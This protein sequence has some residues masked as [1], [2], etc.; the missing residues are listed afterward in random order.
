MKTIA[1]QSPI[2]RKSALA[3]MARALSLA[4]TVVIAGTSQ[5]APIGEGPPDLVAQRIL[6]GSPTV[7]AGEA[8]TQ[9]PNGR[10]LITGGQAS[11]FQIAYL[12]AVSGHR[13]EVQTYLVEGRFDHSATVLPDGSVL[14]FGGR[15][16]DGSVL[17][18]AE[19]FDPSGGVI[20]TLGAVGLLPRAGHTA[21]VLSDGEVLVAGG[22]DGAGQP[23]LQAELY[24]PV[25]RRAERIDLNLDEGRVSQLAALLPNQNVLLWNRK[26]SQLGASA[27]ELL[28]PASGTISHVGLAR[29]RGLTAELA[30]DAVPQIVRTHPERDSSGVPVSEKIVVEFN[31]RMD[32]SSFNDESV[33][34]LG[35]RGV[36]PV[37]PVSV[38][39]GVLLFVAP[40][41][42][43]LPDSSYT[44]FIEGATDE[45]GLA[46]PFTAIGFKTQALGS[47]DVDQSSSAGDQSAVGSNG[48]GTSGG[49]PANGAPGLGPVMIPP[50][51][52]RDIRSTIE[53]TLGS[54][55]LSSAEG[56]SGLSPIDDSE[57]WLPGVQDRRGTWISRR[58]HSG[59]GNRPRNE[60]VDRALY[61]DPDVLGA[62]A[63]MTPANA[64]SRLEALRKKVSDKVR[65]GRTALAGQVLRLNG[66]PLRS[67]TLSIGGRTVATDDN[68]EFTLENVPAGHQ[69]LV[70]DGR[71]AGGS[72]VQYGRFEYGADITVGEVNVLPFL[73]WMSRVDSR[74][75][76]D[77]TSPTT[78]T[79]VLTN[80][81]IPG[82]ELRLPPGTVVRDADGKIATHLS[83][84]AI[85]T[86]QPPFPLPNFPVP[87]YFTV[88]PGGAH[89]ESVDGQPT[90]GAQLV[91]PNFTNSAP[92]TRMTF[93][94]YDSQKK[95]WYVYG[96]GSVTADGT[97][98]MPDP[99]VVIYEFSGAMVSLPGNGPGVGPTPGAGGC[100]VGD[101]VDC[102]TGLFINEGTDLYIKDTIPI[103][104]RRSY[105]QLDN[106]SRGFGI[107]TNLSYDMFLVGD[108]NPYTYQ[109]LILPDGGK[110]HFS[111][112]SS[113]TTFADAVYQSTSAPGRFYGAMIT[114]TQGILD[115]WTLT[116]R[117]GTR[118]GFAEEF[119]STSA[120][121]A[122]IRVITDRNGNQLRMERD[123][124]FALTK[125]V[126]PN[127]R[128]ITLAYDTL[129]RVTDATDDLG[130][131]VHYSYTAAGEL[132]TI[133]YPLG[134][135]EHFTYDGH[136]NMLTVQDK[137]G[138]TMVTN[139]YD[140]NDRVSLQ[141]YADGNT[142]QFAYTLD[143][144]GTKVV[145]TD[146]TTLRGVVR[147]VIFNSN[148]YP[149]SITRAL[150]LP[151]QQVATITRDPATNLLS[152]V[153]DMPLNRDTAYAYDGLGNLKSITRDD[154]SAILF[155]YDPV[156]NQVTKV[157][158]ANNHA[159]NIGLDAEGNASE[160][161]DALSH[162]T[163]ISYDEQG[164]PVGL[165]DPLNHTTNLAYFGGDLSK[166]TD[167]I[168]RSTTW[169]T[170]GAGRATAVSD[171]LRNTRSIQYDALNRVTS[172]TD[173]NGNTISFTYDGNGNILTE[174]DANNNVTTF[175]YDSMN[176]IASRTDALNH[177]ET[178]T[179][180]PAGAFMTHTDR[181]SQTTRVDF[182]AFGRAA[183]VTYPDGTVTNTWDGGSRLT[184]SVD[185]VNGTITRTYDV[186]DRLTK[187]ITPEGTV[188]YTY[189]PQG[190]R[191]TFQITGQPVISYTYD[192]ADRLT[193]IQ[194]AAGT[195]NGN[196][197]QTVSIAYDNANRRSGITL[198]N[199]VTGTYTFD[200][201]NE[202]TSLVY[203]K[204][205]GTVIGDLTYT[206][207]VAGRR[208][209]SGGTLAPTVLPVATTSA[210][211][212]NVNNQQTAWNGTTQTFD[213]NGN[214]TS[215][216]TRAY[217]W[218]VRNQ[219]SSSTGSNTVTF[220]YDAFGRRRARTSSG[221]TSAYLLDGDNIAQK[222]VG[223]TKYTYITGGLDE[224]FGQYASSGMVVPLID[225][226][227]STVA[228][229]DGSQ[230]S[231]S[232]TTYRPYGVST[233]SGGA[234]QLNQQFTGHED[235]PT[236]LVYARARYYSP[237]SGRFI[238]EDP[239]GWAS[240]Q[241]N[242][243][244]YVHGMPT[245]FRDPYGL[246]ADQLYPGEIPIYLERPPIPGSSTGSQ[247]ISVGP[248]SDIPLPPVGP[249]PGESWPRE[250]GAPTPAAP[251]PPTEYH[252]TLLQRLKQL[253][254]GM[255]PP[256][257]QPERQP[258]SPTGVR[259]DNGNNSDPGG[260]MCLV[261]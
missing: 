92:G 235:D 244:A 159:T 5:G 247:P 173:Q 191:A 27:G 135:S 28:N 210:A 242:D 224:V 241:Q 101:P 194:Q 12:D 89:L 16:P 40:V 110:I 245:Q 233:R 22:V 139:A 55:G 151:E 189:D 127:G 154:N 96:H 49:F 178:W 95:G 261:V 14:L 169:L 120:R 239:I 43:L 25:S 162:V 187:E 240:G 190:R 152:N 158:D 172:E 51:G 130:R 31:K 227:G 232:T 39:R 203:K 115:F 59:R 91:Y 20:R 164:R 124:N 182:D 225:A 165:T 220:L 181:K 2:L 175:T 256:P 112:I 228:E 221:T 17:D 193:Q 259:G 209:S 7:E 160:I 6:A 61:G 34:L 200:D 117:D 64:K 184:Q 85:P 62:I 204:S 105:R 199:G 125:I 180:D 81:R 76:V 23:I 157:T 145:Q 32:V 102:A 47:S 197:V 44:L 202:L 21:T 248:D 118:L 195:L 8:V 52:V 230:T 121:S 82:L 183:V 57:L 258:L 11:P 84:T 205:D 214:L 207:D 208:T 234:T 26:T 72:H 142:L 144:T 131:N 176:R 66:R 133:S 48:P 78:G 186:L 128:R 147:R 114:C 188:K 75:A 174:T 111:R 137:R 213:L 223:T 73:I 237:G 140:T 9:I 13:D 138:N 46:L 168:A 222:K 60:Q 45:R 161:T 192:D 198:P 108:T 98:V 69:V 177:A 19:V 71:T 146:T 99:G 106:A 70:I 218:N 123:A 41:Q 196:V 10:W 143:A 38:E 155:D 185:T 134:Y 35:P 77:V 50:S 141:T 3:R 122:A 18:T 83:I 153:N 171:A 103:E 126:S 15:R 116:L 150:G 163:Q 30:S 1:F 132:D 226:L 94:D 56:A 79:T 255:T 87:T 68:G 216:G 251:P 179:Y 80:P 54:Y 166:V 37:R 63:G 231:L 36:T 29:G 53:A 206:Y 246:T 107:G 24:D 136:H 65:K 260:G 58:A 67:V 201:A 113:G 88:Q 119:N 236:A 86:D 93:W 243:Y 238:S 215:D 249:F 104:V 219:L 4:A 74:Y 217:T 212:Y 253:M 250:S 170:D 97:Q 148:G 211:T 33:T 229:L 254:R 42:E 100:R 149:T 109:D 252:P 90:V 257:K 156:F 167:P 129:S